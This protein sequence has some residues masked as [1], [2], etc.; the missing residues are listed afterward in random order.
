V[1][2][3]KLGEGCIEGQLENNLFVSACQAEF[4]PRPPPF[5]RTTFVVVWAERAAGAGKIGGRTLPIHLPILSPKRESGL[6][7]FP[8]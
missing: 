8:R 4:N 3:G 6:E 1:D 7:D 5:F 2:I